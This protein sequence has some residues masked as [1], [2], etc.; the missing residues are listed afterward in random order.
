MNETRILCDN[1]SRLRNAM[2]EL[3]TK[4]EG[5]GGDVLLPEPR[6]PKVATTRQGPAESAKWA[7]QV[8][9]TPGRRS[10]TEESRP[11]TANA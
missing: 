5:V 10:S 8:V 11:G 6:D 4:K 3:F 7:V 2:G 9:K 1:Y